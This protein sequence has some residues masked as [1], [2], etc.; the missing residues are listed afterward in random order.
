MLSVRNGARAIDFYKAAFDADELFRVEGE[1]GS[2]VAQLSVAESH[3]GS[4]IVA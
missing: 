2:V 1:G 3:S 4:L